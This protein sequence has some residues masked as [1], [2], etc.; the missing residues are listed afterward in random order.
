M[1]SCI[2]CRDFHCGL[3]ALWLLVCRDYLRASIAFFPTLVAQQASLKPPMCLPAGSGLRSY[4][5]KD[6]LTD[7]SRDSTPRSATGSAAA[8]LVDSPGRIQPR[9]S[10]VPLLSLA[11]VGTGTPTIANRSSRFSRRT[12]DA[13]RC[14]SCSQ[15]FQL[16][17]HVNLLCGR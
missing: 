2:K 6:S 1:P 12:N 16:I 11:T 5:I 4:P 8:D 9:H 15:G 7:N 13:S 14:G 17:R 3:E 10:V